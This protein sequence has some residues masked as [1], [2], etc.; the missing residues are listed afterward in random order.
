MALP[1]FITTWSKWQ[2][3][4]KIIKKRQ[5]QRPTCRLYQNEIQRVDARCSACFKIKT[6]VWTHFGKSAKFRTDLARLF[7]TCRWFFFGLNLQ[8]LFF[9]FQMSETIIVL[10][11]C[12]HVCYHSELSGGFPPKILPISS[13]YFRT[14]WIITRERHRG[15]LDASVAELFW[16][17]RLRRTA[18]LSDLFSKKHLADFRRRMDE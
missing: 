14:P 16:R 8:L 7:P 18:H 1:S 6:A 17:H 10:L 13:E 2:N 5:F 4:L 9:N 11:V 15:N 3:I 12:R